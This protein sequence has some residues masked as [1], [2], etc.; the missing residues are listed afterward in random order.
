MSRIFR[1]PLVHFLLLG[2][3][4]FAIFG[5][6]GG[7]RGVDDRSIVVTRADVQRIEATWLRQWG[8]PPS[9][10]ET[11]H[12]V[13]QFVREEVL[14]REALGMGLEQGDAATPVPY[15]ARPLCAWQ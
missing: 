7:G 15:A 14:Y 4:L 6:A 9:A 12:L 3:L 5:V 8:R 2:A 11:A 1:E 13:E 10:T